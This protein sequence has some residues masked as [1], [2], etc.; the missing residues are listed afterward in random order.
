MWVIDMLWRMAGG[1]EGFSFDRRILT[2]D[3]GKAHRAV[4]LEIAEYVAAWFDGYQQTFLGGIS[5]INLRSSTKAGNQWLKICRK[6]FSL[7]RRLSCLS[8]P[9]L[10]SPSPVVLAKW[11][12]HKILLAPLE[13]ASSRYPVKTSDLVQPSEQLG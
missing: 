5:M 7:S 12:H 9:L 8:T 1:S 3:D 10:A 13:E 4:Y 2:P 11:P 6:E